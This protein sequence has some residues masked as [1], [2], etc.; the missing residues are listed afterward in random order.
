MTIIYEENNAESKDSFNKTLDQRAKN[1]GS[2]TD[3]AKYQISKNN[4]KNGFCSKRFIIYGENKKEFE[5]YRDERLNYLDPTNPIQVDMCFHLIQIGWNLKRINILR[6]GLQNIEIKNTLEN[7]YNYE[8]VHRNNAK[9]IKNIFKELPDKNEILGI[10][11]TRDCTGSN[12][13]AKLTTIE[14]SFHAKFYKIK[15]EYMFD[16]FNREYDYGK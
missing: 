11:F 7:S 8:D 1:K 10:V 6:T 14:N 9:E 12:T 16:R 13:L 15:R 5:R 3:K 4:I 2:L